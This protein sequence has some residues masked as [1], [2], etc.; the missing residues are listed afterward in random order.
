MRMGDRV[1]RTKASVALPISSSQANRRHKESL[2]S[3]GYYGAGSAD[4][5][6]KPR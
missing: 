6:S 2:A 4:K 1:Y 3:Q 5:T